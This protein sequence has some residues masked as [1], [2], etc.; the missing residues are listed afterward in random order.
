M[1]DFKFAIGD[2]VTL[3]A[4]IDLYE[5]HQ[6]QPLV[7]NE[8]VSQQC[9][10]GEQLVYLC[11]AIGPPNTSRPASFVDEYFRV[12]ESELV[13][14]DVEAYRAARSAVPESFWGSLSNLRKA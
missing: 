5:L 3:K 6:V 1:P 8:R 12:K 11:R 2:C 10:G 4:H 7:V 13:G 14:L 9:E